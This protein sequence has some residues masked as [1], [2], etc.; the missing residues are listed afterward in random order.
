MSGSPSVRRTIAIFVTQ[1]HKLEG[2]AGELEVKE[3]QR[4]AAGALKLDPKNALAHF[5]LGFIHLLY[6]WNWTAAEQEFQQVAIL[7]PGDDL[8]PHG[9]AMLSLALDRWDEALREIKVSLA[10]DPLHPGSFWVLAQIQMRRGHLAEAEAAMR[11]VLDIRPTFSGAHYYL[12]LVLLARGNADAALLEM[13]KETDDAG[14]QYGLAIVKY[15]LANKSA[16]DAVLAQMLRDQSD[17][18]A[19]GIAEMYALRGQSDRAFDWLDRAYRQK[20]S[21]LI[22]IKG[23]WMLRGLERDPRYKAFLRKMNLPE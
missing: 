7:A 18:D 14:K 22:Y 9:E 2:N 8:A 23:D 6:D 12:G 19:G 20:N 15:T 13:Q 17:G 10:R 4:T 5:E 11:R 16:S 1:W 21:G 3:G